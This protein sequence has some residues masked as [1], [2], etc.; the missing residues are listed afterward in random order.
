MISSIIAAVLA[1][2]AHAPGE[3]VPAA[4][5]TM[6]TSTTLIDFGGDDGSKWT[7]IND[8]VMGG[9]SRSKLRFTDR[10]T[11]IFSGVLSLEN[12]G[13]FASARAA[14]GHRDLSTCAGLEIRVRG[15]GRTY[16]LRLRTNNR[17]DGIA[18]RTVFKTRDGEWLTV[19]RAFTEFLPTFRGRTP[20]DA[21]PLDPAQI[22]QVGFLLADK[23]PGEF[24]LEIDFVRTLAA[25][26]GEQ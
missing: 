7:V 6:D 26:L 9:V 3:P 25:A 16:Q 1:L 13:G 11:G 12:K 15:D 5:D 18:Y 19:R 14:V 24:L 20:A 10:K 21:A 2:A 4:G 22:H 23:Q 8:D 17:F